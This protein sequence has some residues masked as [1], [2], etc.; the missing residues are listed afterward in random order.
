MRI[1]AIPGSARNRVKATNG[2]SEEGV[3]TDKD[4]KAHRSDHKGL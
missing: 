4:E 1:L 3:A 2:N